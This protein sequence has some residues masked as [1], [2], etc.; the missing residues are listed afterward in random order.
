MA[1]K[2]NPEKVPKGTR[3]AN[4]ESTIYFGSDGY[5][6]GRVTMGIRD[7]GKPDRRHV[8]RKVKPGQEDR[9]RKVVEKLVSELEKERDEGTARKAGPAWTVAKWLNYW[10]ERIAPETTGESGNGLAAYEVAVRVHLVPGLGAHRLER[11]T[12]EHFEKFYAKMQAAGSSAATAHQAHRTAKTAFNEALR[13]GHIKRNPVALAHPPKLKKKKILPYSVDEVQRIL[14]KAVEQRNSARWAIALALGLRQG[15]VLGMKWEDV[16]LDAGSLNVWRNR[17]RPKYKHGCT[18]PCGKKAGYCP[19]RVA[20]REETGE[21]KSEAGVRTLAL[22]AELVEL[23]RNHK[24]KQA[25]EKA[26]A[27][28]VWAEK[29]YVFTSETGEPLNPRTDYT[30]WKDLLAAAE[31]RDGRLHDA[32]HTAAT[33]LLLLK[34]P[35]RIVMDLMGWSSESMATRYQHV[36]GEMREDVAKLVGDLIWKPPGEAPEEPSEVVEE[37]QADTDEKGSEAGY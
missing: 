5:C 21:T 36:T 25:K 2:K 31:I 28:S 33:V 7:D 9:V 11:I 14:A 30:R 1:V 17:L 15:E 10:I 20:A 19:A 34:I 22:P 35:N 23:L 18:N 13:R 29:G 3:A 26:E 4:G 37:D 32:R 27:G 24:D 16:D 6:H 12:P 8:K